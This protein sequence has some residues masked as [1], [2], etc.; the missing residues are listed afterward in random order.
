M[1]RSPSDAALGIVV[2]ARAV[3]LGA[4][5]TG[6]DHLRPRGAASAAGAACGRWRGR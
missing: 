3:A 1:Q 5:F 2:L 6:F 4:A